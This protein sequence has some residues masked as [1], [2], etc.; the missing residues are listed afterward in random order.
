MNYFKLYWNILSFRYKKAFACVA[1]AFTLGL[2]EGSALLSLIPIFQSQ[3][4]DAPAKGVQWAILNWLALPFGSGVSARLV[5][6]FILGAMTACLH[7]ATDATLLSMRTNIEAWLRRRMSEAL[8]SMDWTYY[9]NLKQGDV[10][11][12]FIA[13]GAQVAIGAHSFLAMLGT[14]LI[15]LTF[16]VMALQVSGRFTLCALSAGALGLILLKV[17]AKK[18]R[19]RSDELTASAS[20]VGDRVSVLF[21]NL[22]FFKSTGLDGETLR[23]LDGDFQNASNSIFRSYL[24]GA[25]MR[26]FSELGVVIL[27]SLLLFLMIGPKIGSSSSALVLLFIFYRLTPRLLTIQEHYHNS[28]VA[29]SWYKAWF[30]RFQFASNHPSRVNP[31]K[32]MLSGTGLRIERVGFSYPGA[33]SPVLNEISFHANEGECIAIVGPSGSGKSTVLDLIIGLL[34]PT[35]GDIIIGGISHTQLD[36]GVWR[37]K[38]GLVMQESP[39]FH[40]SILENIAY[41]SGEPDPGRAKKAACMAHAWGFIQHLPHGMNSIIGENGGRLSVGQRQRLALA[42]ALYREPSVLILDEATSALDGAAEA[43][44]QNAIA[45]I[46]GTCTI[47]MVSHRIKTVQIADRILVLDEGRIMETGTWGELLSNP[48][49]LFRQMAAAQGIQLKG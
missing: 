30:A 18:R 26:L 16:L 33:S 3:S 44:V 24:Y 6:F 25:K 9:L 48:D 4:G 31:G 36:L 23:G 43:E 8:V 22:K 19:L 12:T 38:L 49:G 37:K 42:R 34:S 13:E 21:Q 17:T 41:G 29:L 2:F 32:V 35:K 45:K 20:R 46:K 40:V 15:A 28:Q 11:H 27:V 10:S 14:G 7:F 1:L 39:V 47:L 5:V